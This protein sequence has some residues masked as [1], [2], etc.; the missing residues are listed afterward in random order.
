LAKN[1]RCEAKMSVPAHG[2]FLWEIIY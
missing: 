1:N 2:L